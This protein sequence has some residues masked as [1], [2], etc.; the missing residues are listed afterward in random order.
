MTSRK[1][2]AAS[3]S[4]VA[5]RIA[6]VVQAFPCT[7]DDED[8]KAKCTCGMPSNGHSKHGTA[9]SYFSHLDSA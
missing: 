6:Q 4:A 8:H 7:C 1:V 3:S 5:N 2:I 9:F